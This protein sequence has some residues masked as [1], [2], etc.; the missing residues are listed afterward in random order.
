MVL[1]FKGGLHVHDGKELTKDCAVKPAPVPELLV[2]PLSQ[3]IGAPCEAIVK[4]KDE[5]LMGQPVGEAK[6]FVSAPVHSP[7]SGKVKDVKAAAHHSGGKVLSVIIQNDGEDRLYEGVD[8]PVDPASLTREEMI[9]RVKS[10]GIVGLGGATFPAHVKLSP[11]K[12]KPIDTVIVN[13]AE[14]EPLL[15]CDYRL[16]MESTETVILGADLVRKLVGARRLILATE[17]NKRDAAAVLEAK[18]ADLGLEDTHVAV[19]KTKYPQGGERQLIKA[20]LDREVPTPRKRGLPMDVGVIVHNVGTC[21]TIHAAITRGM[22]LIERLVTVVGDAVENPGNYSAR[23]GTP[24]QVLLSDA[25]MADDPAA[26][27]LGG[28]MMGMSVYTPEVP[29]AK[30]TSGI[31]AL[32]TVRKG[33]PRDCIRCASCV[34]VCPARLTPLDLSVAG[35]SQRWDVAE[36]YHVD[37]CIECGCCSY[38]CPANRPIVHQ[39]RHAKAALWKIRSSQAS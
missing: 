35:E 8:V 6:G 3:H 34:E 26:I 1:T 36:E 31:L 29:V 23:I 11:P 4:K 39:I 7:V 14:C 12:D 22:P 25:G 15:T 28:P 20:L 19:A 17:D 38:V 2:V 21:H 13:G 9:E 37:D 10:A 27:L 16:M 33:E 32:S 30:G 18:V 5:V 24:I